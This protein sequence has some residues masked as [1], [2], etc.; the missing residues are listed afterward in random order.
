MINRLLFPLLGETVKAKAIRGSLW[1][2]SGI[3]ASQGLRLAGNLILTRILFP[4]AFGLMAIVQ[5][6]L[7]GLALFSDTGINLSI[8]QHERGEDPNFLNTAWTIQ[9]IRGG[10]LWFGACLLAWPAA[11]FYDDQLLLQ[12]LPVA[13][14]SAFVGGF[15]PTK[16]VTANRRLMLGRVTAIEIG[17][18]FITLT[19]LVALALIFRSVWALVIGDILGEVLKLIFQRRFLSGP[20]NKFLWE[21]SAARELIKFGKWILL[22][23]ACGFLIGQGD[24]AILGKFTSFEQLGVYN[25]GFFLASFPLML[26][27]VVAERVIFPL[28]KHKPP[29]ASKDNQHNLFRARFMLIGAMLILNAALGISG[30]WLVGELYDSRYLLAGPIL[31][32][33]SVSAVPN[34]VLSTHSGVLLAEG[35]SRRFMILLISTAFVQSIT[36]FLGVQIWGIAGVALASGF[37]T[38]ITCP[39][40]Q[41]FA[42]RY[43]AWN[44]WHDAIFL[45]LGL[46]VGALSVWIHYDVIRVLF[47]GVA[48]VK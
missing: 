41:I 5:V 8:I 7:V 16:A 15:Q 9:V 36:L 23:T 44:P 38:L 37:S 26:C 43:A 2:S 32:L 22:S 25:I 19:T 46:S 17:S 34:I 33:V 20:N 42:K 39:L 30:V 14:I 1:A 21:R 4:E 11:L 12:L 47:G 6:F 40:T 27:R 3:I 48:F 29:K 31:V 28:Y 45:I 24:R 13:G 10:L 18:Q 35:D